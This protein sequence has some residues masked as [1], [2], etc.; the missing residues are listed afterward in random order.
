MVPPN[1]FSVFRTALR[2]PQFL[3]YEFTE[4][5]FFGTEDWPEQVWLWVRF[6]P[7]PVSDHDRSRSPIMEWTTV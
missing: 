4:A 2:R 7:Y 6:T 1:R 3:P 5:D